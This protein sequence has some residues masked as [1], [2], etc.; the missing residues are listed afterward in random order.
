M[1]PEVTLQ[2][3]VIGKNGLLTE[4]GV[5]NVA[6]KFQHVNTHINAKARTL[7]DRNVEIDQKSA[8]L[9]CKAGHRDHIGRP[10]E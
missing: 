6:N 2:V 8:M 4:G 3:P 5:W 10:A 7:F 1:C 9:N